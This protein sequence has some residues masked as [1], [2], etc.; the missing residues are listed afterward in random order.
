MSNTR[1][2]VTGGGGPAAVGFM[3][4]VRGTGVD[5]FVGDIDPY[6]AGL[7]LVG[8]SRRF[9]LPR[10]ESPE[11]VDTLLDLCEREHIEVLVPTVD[12]ELLPVSRAAAR[13]TRIGVRVVLAPES[14]LRTCLDKWALL[15][16]CAGI[17]RVPRS[18][19]LDT[20]FRPDDWDLPAIVKP[21]T[22]S[23]SR[24]VRL[25]E[26]AQDLDGLPRDGRLLVQ[27]HLPGEEYSVDVLVDPADR[28]VVAAVPRLRLKVDSGIAVTSRTVADDGLMVAA[29]A[30]AER[31]GLTFVGNI[32]FKR[33]RD[34]RP[35]LLEVNPR[36]PGTMSLTVAAGI[37]MPH[38]AV[39][40]ALGTGL[41][42]VR[43]AFTE[44]AVVRTW[45]DHFFQTSELLSG[46]QALV[47]A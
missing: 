6:A 17:V 12:C 20:S 36:F 24:G 43:Y 7:Y 4:G 33:D 8:P 47:T 30:V 14:A 42:G 5:L 9:L 38:L 22:G 34:G 39:A 27:E 28:V 16:T 13:F 41:T 2:L 1:V 29:G 26:S 11:F 18:A 45:Q 3:S 15:Q 32:Q 46:S 25:V 23:G 40:A 21:R 44:L 35:A 37:N 10:G 31:V 19:P